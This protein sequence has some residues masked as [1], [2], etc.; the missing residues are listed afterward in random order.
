M[1]IILLDATTQIDNNELSLGVSLLNRMRYSKEPKTGQ[2]FLKKPSTR[3]VNRLQ[4]INISLHN[5]VKKFKQI[6]KKK[7]LLA[8]FVAHKIPTII[9]KQLKLAIQDRL[10]INKKQYSSKTV[11][12]TT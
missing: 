6:R 12:M 2:I 1:W 9:D 3:K 5:K 4:K 11:L 8:R 10:I 7:I